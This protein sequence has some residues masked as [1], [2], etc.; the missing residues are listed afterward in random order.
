MREHLYGDVVRY[1]KYLYVLRPLLAARWIR[2][3]R[4]VPPMRFAHLACELLTDKTIFDEINALL[5]LKMRSGEAATGPR[6]VPIHEFLE[7]ELSIALTYTPE[8]QIKADI[9]SLNQYFLEAVNHFNGP[10]K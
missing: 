8:K 2:E 10:T 7:Q 3:G 5:E 6:L 9:T 4:G 1:K